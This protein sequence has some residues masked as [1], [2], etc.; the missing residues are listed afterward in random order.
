MV[1]RNGAFMKWGAKCL[2]RYGVTVFLGLLGTECLRGVRYR[3]AVGEIVIFHWVCQTQEGEYCPS[4]FEQYEPG[5]QHHLFG[6]RVHTG[7][8]EGRNQTVRSTRAQKHTRTHKRTHYMTVKGSRGN[9][10]PKPPNVI[11]V[12]I[13]KRERERV[14][15]L[16]V[17]DW[18]TSCENC[19]PNC[20][21][22]KLA[23]YFRLKTQ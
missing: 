14:C 6:P 12:T 2:P 16:G 23:V 10:V 18:P 21:A 13:E 17:R 4:W 3:N 20:M 19:D 9:F 22:I 1:A 15:Y 11:S 7:W 5:Q 8:T